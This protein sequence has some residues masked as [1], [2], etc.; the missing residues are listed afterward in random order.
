MN[1]EGEMEEAFR[2]AGLVIKK[3]NDSH[4]FDGV[5]P[6]PNFIQFFPNGACLIAVNVRNR[7][8]SVHIRSE[9]MAVMVVVFSER[10]T[11][12]FDEYLGEEYNCVEWKM[13]K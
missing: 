3:K 13:V 11:K 6:S 4:S 9:R 1:I 10:S 5:N 8:I 2:L 7:V 12:P